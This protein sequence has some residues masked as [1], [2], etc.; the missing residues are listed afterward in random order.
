MYLPVTEISS[1]NHAYALHIASKLGNITS[2]AN[3][4]SITDYRNYQSGLK[5]PLNN[6]HTRE[7]LYCPGLN[8]GK[9]LLQ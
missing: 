2:L 7:G 9:V 4:M 8:K 6:M 1:I 3:A 5:N